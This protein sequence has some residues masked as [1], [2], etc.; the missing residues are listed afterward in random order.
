M[1]FAVSIESGSRLRP[2]EV[3]TLKLPGSAACRGTTGLQAS[4]G[5]LDIAITFFNQYKHLVLI[6]SSSLFASL[7]VQCCHRHEFCAALTLLVVCHCSSSCSCATR[8]VFLYL[9]F[10]EFFITPSFRFVRTFVLALFFLL[11]HHFILCM[12]SRD[13]DLNQVTFNRQYPSES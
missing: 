5:R 1:D 8:T 2:N 4:Y 7:L 12:S 6:T 13:P 3:N 10:C 9:I 11:V